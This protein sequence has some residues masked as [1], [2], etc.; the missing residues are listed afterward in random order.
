MGATAWD[1]F[2]R[3][4]QGWLSPLA[5]R[6]APAE[7]LGGDWVSRAAVDLGLPEPD[8]LTSAIYQ[9]SRLGAVTADLHL[10]LGSFSEDPDIRPEAFS[11]HYQ[12]SLYQSLLA[13]IR[14]QLAVIRRLA[15]RAGPTL[16]P[17]VV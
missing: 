1:E 5:G 4:A 11:S 17:L 14:Q 8:L 9:A 10:A 7:P 3:R 16:A 6:A 13:G 2:H 12:Q 15:G